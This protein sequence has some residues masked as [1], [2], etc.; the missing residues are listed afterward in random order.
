MSVEKSLAIVLR[1]VDFS[2]TSYIVRLYTREFGKISA[3]AKGAKRPKNSF[4]AGLDLLS[5]CRIVFLHKSSDSLD[6]LTEAK[7]ERRFRSANLDLSRL[8][9]GYYVT[10]LVSDFTDEGES[11]PAIFDLIR[12]TIVAIDEGCELRSIL[13]RFEMSLLRLIGHIP[14]LTQCVGCGQ[15]IESKRRILFALSAGG[16]IC[17]RCRSGQQN[18]ASVSLPV[19]DTLRNFEKHATDSTE[20]DL[21]SNRIHGE[22]RAV[23]NQFLAHQ[24]GHKP[25]TLAFLN[26]VIR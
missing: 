9:S 7:Q 17:S 8:Y 16:V 18:I 1:V 10:E 20:V 26:G 14:S 19:I 5:I 4:D 23:M 11:Q 24:L 15:P 3:L 13:L 6:L 2:E 22:L 12:D 21:I 25:R